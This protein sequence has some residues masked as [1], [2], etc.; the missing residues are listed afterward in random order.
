[1]HVLLF[2]SLH[3]LPPPEEIVSH[4]LHGVRGNDRHLVVSGIP[5]GNRPAIRNQM[6][7]PLE[8]QAQIPH[9]QHR[10]GAPGENHDA[11]F[12]PRVGEPINQRRSPRTKSGVSPT[13]K[14]LPYDE[15]PC[16]FS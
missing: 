14:R 10:R 6:H 15:S 4:R 16:Q 1:M 9:N 3:Q 13:K 12:L 11:P 8:H 2:D 5:P 7:T